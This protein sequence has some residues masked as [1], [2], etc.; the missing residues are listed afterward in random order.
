MTTRQNRGIVRKKNAELEHNMKSR[1]RNNVEQYVGTALLIT[2][3]II[4]RG[5][6][7]TASC[8]LNNVKLLC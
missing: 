4:Y 5:I 6:V 3:S 2:H 7:S 1:H 8:S